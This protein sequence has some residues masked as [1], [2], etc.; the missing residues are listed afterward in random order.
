MSNIKSDYVLHPWHGISPGKKIPD[1]VDAFI[2][3]LP[4]DTVKYE[5][6]KQSA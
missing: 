4:T 2:E 1:E 6:D 5:V 3:M